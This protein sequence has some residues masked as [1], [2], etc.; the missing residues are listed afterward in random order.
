MTNGHPETSQTLDRGLQLLLLLSED[1]NGCT[2][3]ELAGALGVARPVVY[4]LLTTLEQRHL[5][6]RGRDG[7]VRLGLGVL[8]LA[9]RVQPLL[10]EVATPLLRQLADE[11]GATAHLSVAD[12]D[13]ALAVVVVEPQW[14]QFHVA[15][16]VGSRHPLERGAAGRAILALRAG[17]DE[18]ATSDGELQQGAHGV[19]VG[20]TVGS[21]QGSVGVVSLT[22][23]ELDDVG[24]AVRAT[25]DQ[26]VARL[27]P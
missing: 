2:V 25:C 5:A 23:L 1:D 14:T 4:R 27:A 7:R 22:P 16:R 15:Y 10:R 9:A 26:L 21:L 8:A 3:T 24:P 12:G 20:W 17:R 11:V 6:T 19:A 18:P 13:E